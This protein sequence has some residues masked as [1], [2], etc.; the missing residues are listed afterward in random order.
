[1]CPAA[2]RA[3]L[4]E[5]SSIAPLAA[6]AAQAPLDRQRS[7]LAYHGYDR[8]GPHCFLLPQLAVNLGLYR[9]PALAAAQLKPGRIV[10]KDLRPYFA[11][12]DAVRLLS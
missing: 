4:A 6:Q 5:R 1:M 9:P 11:A 10:T 2:C 12:R 8:A 7:A 3:S